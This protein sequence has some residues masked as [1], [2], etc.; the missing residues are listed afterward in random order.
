[1]AAVAFLAIAD[2]IVSPHTRADLA[3]LDAVVARPPAELDPALRAEVGLPSALDGID[4]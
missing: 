1:M 2:A 3:W 4:D